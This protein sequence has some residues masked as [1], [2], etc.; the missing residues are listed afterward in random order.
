MFLFLVGV[1]IGM[2]LAQ[3]FSMPNVQTLL[4]RWSVPAPAP[5]PTPTP[6]DI[7]TQPAFTGD[8]PVK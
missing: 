6:D 3:S 2:W 5:V 4:S 8:M 7:P 1:V